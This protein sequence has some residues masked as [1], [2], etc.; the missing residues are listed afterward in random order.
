MP[1]TI[2]SLLGEEAHELRR[3][4]QTG[5]D[6]ELARRRAVVAVSLVGIGCMAF[7]TLLQMGL[8]KDLPDPPRGN[9]HTKRVNS[10]A[11]AYSFG[12]PDSPVTIVAH[13]VNIAL[14]AFGGRERADRHPWVSV[15]ASVA[16]GIPAAVAAKYLFHQMPRVEKAWCPYC[17]ADALA[18]FATFALTVPETIRALQ[19]SEARRLERR[20]RAVVRR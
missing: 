11:T 15:L 8:V 12:G 3:Y 20:V 18:H 10:S 5:D 9:F 4:L 13:G 2:T 1:L 6:E 19:P 16:A 14:A 17:I 7:T